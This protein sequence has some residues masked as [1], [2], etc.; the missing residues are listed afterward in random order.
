[1]LDDRVE[2][3]EIEPPPPVPSRRVPTWALVVAILIVLRVISIA[4]L[5]NSGVEDKHSILGGDA[6]RY[7]AILATHGTPYRDFEVEY[8]PVTLG[9]V[10]VLGTGID[11]SD[12]DPT[13]G[14]FDGDLGLLTR[15]A[16]VQLGFELGAAALLAWAWNRRT[17]IAYLILGTPFLFFPFPYVR[18]DLVAVF[19]AVL[20]LSLMRKGLD[21][22]GGVA[23][24][25][26]ALAKLWPLVLAPLLIITGK[27]RS[28]VSWAIT[29]GVGVALW[30]AFF[31]PAGFAQVA[32]FRG[33]K[34][35]QI[36]SIPGIFFHMADQA[37]SH[38]EQGAWR[39]GVQ[40]PLVVKPLLPMLAL[41][42]AA[43]AWRWARV[44][45]LSNAD[46]DDWAMWALAP[47]ASILGLL[48]FSTIISPQYV[49]W[50]VP[51]VAILAARGERLITG[52]YLATAVLTTF[53]LA[54]IHGQIAGQLYA[55][56]PIVARNFCLIAM[57][58]ISLY[59]LSPWNRP[60]DNA[61]GQRL[62]AATV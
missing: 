26:A 35:W 50:F 7:E 39:T 11:V 41:G 47:L 51:F 52:I 53:I 60:Q 43:L 44:R 1:M 49:L 3:G 9:L 17:G 32:T 15:L 62:A 21:R 36:E 59:R 27:R 29:M 33:S 37:A 19:L 13:V 16:V 42:N 14:E 28:L 55:T 5:L 31:G 61:D 18:I 30:L 4:F 22:A 54:T 20:A 23:L 12:I 46:E 10:S 45:H 6:R 40:V 57:L 2:I 34:G 38:V 24:A 48:V 56:L 8:P 58:T 25:V